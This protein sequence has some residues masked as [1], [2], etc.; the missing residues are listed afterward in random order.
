MSYNIKEIKQGIK[1]H[2]IDTNKFKTNLLAVFITLPLNREGI[3]FD[4]MIP[5]VLKRGTANLKT[6]E[7]IS[8]KLENMYGTSFDCGIEKIGDNHVI[9]FYLEALNDNFIPENN[10]KNII[11][12]S[13]NLLLDI[14]LNPLTE[15]NYFK[16]EYVQAEK[17]NIKLLIESKIDNKDQYALNRCIEEMYKNKPYGLYK[18]GYVEDL[19]NINSKNL[20]EYYTKLINESKIDIFISGEL[21]NKDIIELV[22]Q[23]ENIKK[24]KERKPNYIIN[25]EQ[26]EQK[27]EISKENIIEEKLDVAQGKLIIGLDVKVNDYNSKFP[28]SL[29]NVILGESATSKLFQ[30]VREKASLAYTA[31]S[32]YVRQ[33]NNIYIRCG[34]EVKNFEKAVKIIKE[35]LLEMSEGKLTQEDLINSKKYMVSGLQSV[36]DEQDSEITYYIGQEL[37]GKLTTFNE[38]I[39]EINK[40]TLEDVKN[41]ANKININTIYFLKN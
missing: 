31:R 35:Q 28:V 33:K 37:S 39:E 41:V 15:N 22:S 16:K 23:N 13:I 6:Q 8:K 32:N 24:I 1:L 34:I 40:V 25:N 5:A 30:N 4:S 29:Y 21:N 2:C 26:T 36:E 17:N 3:T 14:I 27:E 9:K 11:K 7:E 20:Y 12:S 18:Y 19:E 10:N 38:Y